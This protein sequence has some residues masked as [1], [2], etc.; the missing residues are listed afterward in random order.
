MIGLLKSGDT[1]F[2]VSHIL[3]SLSKV[4]LDARRGAVG[5]VN[6]WIQCGSCK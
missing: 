5:I 2:G 4:L 6:A 1:S 3:E